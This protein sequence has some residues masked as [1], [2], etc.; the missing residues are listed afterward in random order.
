M[1][2]TRRMA[3]LLAVPFFAAGVWAAAGSANEIENQVKAAY[4]YKFAAYVEWPATVFV[5]AD[6]PLTIGILGAEAIAAELGNLKSTQPMQNRALEVKRLK[7]GEALTGVQILFIG[8]QEN[9]R[10]KSLLDSIQSQSMLVVTES[11]GALDAG[12]VINFLPVGDRIRFEV[13]VQNAERSGLKIS[14]RLLGVAQKIEPR[15]P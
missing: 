10:L 15:R 11:A 12:S 6:T 8:R 13:S 1:A 2:R 3:L 5:Q 4:L 14:A 7:P 9:G